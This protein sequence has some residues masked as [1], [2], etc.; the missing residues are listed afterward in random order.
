MF[1]TQLIALEES[2]YPQMLHFY[3]KNEKKNATDHWKFICLEYPLHIIYHYI[4][5]YSSIN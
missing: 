2:K 1:W 5:D 3:Y 4:T